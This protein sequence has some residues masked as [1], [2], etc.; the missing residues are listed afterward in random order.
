MYS[1]T[2]FADDLTPTCRAR[3][4]DLSLGKWSTHDAARRSLIGLLTACDALNRPRS[5][6]QY[7]N[8]A[9]RLSGQTSIFGVFFVSK[10]LLRTEGQKKLENFA[11]LPRKPGS[12]A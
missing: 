1:L 2:R 5:T 6:C 12:H 9:P 4:I 10:S 3:F 11:I 8:M 7:F